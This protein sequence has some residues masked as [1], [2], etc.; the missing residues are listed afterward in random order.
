[1]KPVAAAALSA[2]VLLALPL[3]AQTLIPPEC[4]LDQ[5]N[6]TFNSCKYC[7][8]SGLPGALNNEIER[9][10]AFPATENLFLN[11]LDPARLD[12]LVPPATIPVD[13]SGYLDRDNYHPAL[14]A[15]GSDPEVGA[16][17]GNLKF[18]PDLDPDQTG[19]EGFATNGWR[20]FKW[21]PNELA[22][23]RYNGRIQQNWVRLADK[24]Q[25]AAS[26]AYDRETY[27]GN[28]D[29]LVEALRGTVQSGTYLGLAA[30]EPVVP[31]RF[32]AGTEILHYLYY[33]D[34]SQPDMK[35]RRIKEVRWNIKSVPEQYNQTYFAYVSPKEKEYSYTYRE[36]GEKAAAAYGLVYNQDGW[37]IIGF[38]EDPQGELRPQTAG[39]MSQCLGCHSG[40]MSS[41]VDSHWNSLQRKLP[42]EAGWTLQDY[43]GIPDDYNAYLGRGETG[44]IFE[45]Y[46][47]DASRMPTNSDGT[48]N[49]LP[50]PQE[51]D[52]LTRRYYQ[53][54]QSQSYYLG[55]DPK[56]GN[57]G[58][59]RQPSVEKFRSGDQLALWYPALDFSRF[60]LGPQITAVE[61]ELGAGPGLPF[62]L[63]PNYPNPFN[64]GTQIR[65]QLEQAGPVQ[66]EIRSLAGQVVRVLVAQAQAA[67]RYQVQ[68]DG[69]D[70]QG[71]AAGSG[72]YLCQLRQGGLRETRK[73]LLLR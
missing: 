30:D 55:R 73:L 25:R 4:Y 62:A 57:P 16:G 3:W 11:V 53:I 66:L 33:L 65:Y 37:D 18:F 10:G 63:A 59:L 14:A 32:P 45:N 26:G 35:A 5:K 31:Y 12:S 2:L 1:M 36:G 7:H 47:G 71:R 19:P 48:I 67:G 49:F 70:E 9:Q 8:M 41:I 72:L 40:R 34:P 23:P 17:Q 69:M 20:A 46:E 43:R 68:W 51:A 38:I 61:E 22:W 13:L 24:F 27:K 44:E 52:A 58:F 28:L 29:L 56:L 6:N 15:R 60:D 50:T 54:V 21:K 64:A 39:E 42:G